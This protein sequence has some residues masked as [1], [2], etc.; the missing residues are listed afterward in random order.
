MIDFERMDIA[1]VTCG[2]PMWLV[3]TV[4]AWAETTP[5]YHRIHAI[6]NSE[7]GAAAADRLRGY[8]DLCV[9]R[10]GR[11]PEHAGN[12]AQSWNLAMLWAFRDS[13]VEWLLCSQDDVFV[14]PG[15]PAALE[16]YDAD[17][18]VAPV[19]DVVFLMN[20]R[21][22]RKVGW[23][24]ERFTTIGWHEWDW[25]YRALR[26]LGRDRVSIQDGHGWE[27]HPVGLGDFWQQPRT[28]CR[29][30]RERFPGPLMRK[31][32]R[33]LKLNDGWL[34]EKWGM[35]HG[36]LLYALRTGDLRPQLV[37]E[38]DWYPW[39]DRRLEERNG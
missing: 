5:T 29:Q 19:G 3:A 6:C 28:E 2:R 10:T 11:P 32:E 7:D 33:H 12:L 15:W 25:Q 31:N 35:D 23:F 21:V 18:Y 24:D 34:R 27:Y 4:Q 38:V 26:D 14:A 30:D 17:L 36:G 20:R 1:V 13:E 9:H 8:D 37:P 22:L 16:R 39:F